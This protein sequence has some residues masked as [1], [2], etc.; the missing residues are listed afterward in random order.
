MLVLSHTTPGSSKPISEDTAPSQD[1]GA[2]EYGDLFSQARYSGLAFKDLPGFTRSVYE[3]DHALVA[4]ES[5]VWAGQRGWVNAVTAHIISPRVGAN[6][7]MYMAQLRENGVAGPVLPGAERFIMVLQGG[8]DVT[9]SAGASPIQLGGSQYAYFPANS[10]GSFSSASGSHVLVYER[11]ASVK[12]N[13]EF[14]HGVTDE[15]PLL[16]TPGEVFLLRK[17]LPQTA[18]YDFNIHIMDFEP[19]QF[20]NVKEV[21]YNQHGMLMLEGQGIYRLANSWYPIQAGDAV[22]MAP[23]VIQW[24]A[25][26]GTSRTR[27]ILYKDTTADPLE[28]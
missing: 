23:F 21:H 14:R 22:W 6:F 10:T 19:G 3:R 2:L 4:P 17:L 15:S 1:A 26:L 20:L 8:V 11:M 24:Y 5:R 27:Y 13:A 18:D 7:V 9:S 28:L 16:P 12:G 25:A